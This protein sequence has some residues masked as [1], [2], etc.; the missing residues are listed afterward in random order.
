MIE[1]STI[2]VSD[3]NQFNLATKHND[4][5]IGQLR[6]KIELQNTP[7]DPRLR[8]AQERSCCMAQLRVIDRP[9]AETHRYVAVPRED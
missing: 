2:S 1:F 5:Q 7:Q 4:P 9:A 3:H 6:R 8:T